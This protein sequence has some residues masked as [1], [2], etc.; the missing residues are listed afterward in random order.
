MS[1]FVV[2]LVRIFPHSEQNNAEH[3]RILRCAIGFPYMQNAYFKC[4][5][6]VPL[7]PLPPG[8]NCKTPPPSDQTFS[9]LTTSALLLRQIQT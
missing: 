8:S 6:N 2:I 5:T 4:L 1:V 3:G 9:F 7:P